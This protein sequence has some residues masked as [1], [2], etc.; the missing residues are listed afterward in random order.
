MCV[1]ATLSGCHLG[2]WYGV[3]LVSAGCRVRLRGV[4]LARWREGYTRTLH[5]CVV[6]GYD[7]AR[8]SVASVMA[9]CYWAGGVPPWLLVWGGGAGALSGCHL[10]F[11]YG[12]AG[13]TRMR[14]DAEAWVP[15]AGCGMGRHGAENRKAVSL[16]IR[17]CIK[18]KLFD[19]LFLYIAIESA[20]I[21][22]RPIFG[23]FPK[24]FDSRGV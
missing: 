15:V 19:T 11:W 14:H 20:K 13:L 23:D 21:I 10:G 3:P 9:V 16:I 24:I 22:K 18:N 4:P 7:Q 5:Y 17:G 1:G 12:G 6:Q 8:H 2:F